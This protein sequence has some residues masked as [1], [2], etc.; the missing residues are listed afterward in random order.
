MRIVAGSA[1]EPALALPETPRLPQTVSLIYDFKPLFAACR[2]RF[3][4]I[5]HV[6]AERFAGAERKRLAI[7]TANRSRQFRASSFQMTLHTYVHLPL[8]A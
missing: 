5:Q 1:I 6:R 7:E 2:F 4:E 8:R 3:V